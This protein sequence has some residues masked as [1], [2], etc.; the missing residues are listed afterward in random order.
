[1]RKVF[2]YFIFINVVNTCMDMYI[3]YAY[4][5]NISQFSSH[6]AWRIIIYKFFIYSF[7]MIRWFLFIVT[8]ENGNMKKIYWNVEKLSKIFLSKNMPNENI[9]ECFATNWKWFFFVLGYYMC[10]VWDFLHVDHLQS[11]WTNKSH[12]KLLCMSTWRKY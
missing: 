5:R 1:M 7:L 12:K 8:Y 3:G 9:Y 11:P 6:M 10:F 4:K 2:C